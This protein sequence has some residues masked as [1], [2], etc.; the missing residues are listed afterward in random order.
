M[1]LKITKGH[2][3]QKT[4]RNPREWQAVGTGAVEHGSRSWPRRCNRR[5]GGKTQ[6][7]QPSQHCRSRAQAAVVGVSTPSSNRYVW[8]RKTWHHQRDMAPPGWQWLG[9]MG[10]SYAQKTS[11]PGIALGNR[12]QPS[13]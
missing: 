2:S 11:H 5:A 13:L 12:S 4:R 10:N 3:K 1:C 8:A 6:Q 9:E 7:E